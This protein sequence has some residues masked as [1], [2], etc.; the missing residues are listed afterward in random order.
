MVADALKTLFRDKMTVFVYQ[1]EKQEG[2]TVEKEMVFAEK[3]PCYLSF[4]N[5]TIREDGLTF[6][7]LTGTVFYPFGAEIPADSK[8]KVLKEGKEYTFS[9]SGEPRKY[10]T[11][12]ELTVQGEEALKSR[13]DSQ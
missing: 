7:R 12:G 13:N 1:R 5:E 6:F 9:V 4:Q 8:I 10:L 3:I 11:H 2:R